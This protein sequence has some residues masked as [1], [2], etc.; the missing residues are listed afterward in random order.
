[1]KG[2]VG[3]W[4]CGQ[5]FLPNYSLNSLWI[6]NNITYLLCT[7][8]GLIPVCTVS[9]SQVPHRLL[10]LAD[11]P[12]S[13]HHAKLQVSFHLILILVYYSNFTDKENKTQE[14]KVQDL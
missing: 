12:Y 4:E 11:F 13:K 1:M 9:L 2:S 10:Y 3:F 6:K 7:G 5:L 14:V 8:H